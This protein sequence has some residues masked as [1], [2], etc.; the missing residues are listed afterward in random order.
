MHK[1]LVT[2]YSRTGNTKMVAEAIFGALDGDKTILPI[3]EVAKQ[4]SLAHKNVGLSLPLAGFPG[5]IDRL[6]VGCPCRLVLTEHVQIVS[7]IVQHARNGTR[8][9]HL[10][11]DAQ[12]S[13]LCLSNFGCLPENA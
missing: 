2:Y 4:V 9:A 1:T 8:N 13:L 11:P 10:A 12:C 3:A 7:D 5:P 6:L